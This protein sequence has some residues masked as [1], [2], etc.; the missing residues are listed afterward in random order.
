MRAS[1]NVF[2]SENTKKQMGK[3]GSIKWDKFIEDFDNYLREYKMHY[4][5]SQNGNEISLSLYPYM[6]EKC[7]VLKGKINKA[8]EK[9]HL[10]EN[11]I[12]K[13]IKLIKA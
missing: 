8:N 11:Q 7:E 3:C 10:S 4:R 13:S 6:R 5:N 12:N 9:K 2:V 1:E